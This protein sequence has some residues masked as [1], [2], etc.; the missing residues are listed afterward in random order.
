MLIALGLGALFIIKFSS[1]DKLLFNSSGN[2]E[3]HFAYGIESLLLS[4]A[5][6][7]F[8]GGSS[9]IKQFFDLDY[10]INTVYLF[11]LIVLALIISYNLLISCII[12][13]SV[14]RVIGKWTFLVVSTILGFVIGV[15]GAVA[16]L[17]IIILYLVLSFLKVVF[18]GTGEKIEVKDSWGNKKTLTNGFGGEWHD[19]MGNGYE[20]DGNDFFKK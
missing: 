8:T 9:F 10:D 18:L 6:G 7:G 19:S 2:D 11:A 16:L 12:E 17:S 20:K 14:G 13:D 1:L 3:D 15:A 4:L 5:I